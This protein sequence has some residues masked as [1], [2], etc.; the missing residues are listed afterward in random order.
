[1]K[2]DLTDLSDFN[3]IHSGEKCF[4]LGAGPSIKDLNLGAIGGHVVICVNSS[5]LLMDW[6]GGSPSRRYWISNDRQC[7]HWDYF[8]KQVVR[9]FS[10]KLI[11]TSWKKYNEKIS[12]FGFRYFEPRISEVYPFNGRDRG[13]CFGSSVPTAIDFAIMMGC[14]KVYLLGVDHKFVHGNSHFWQFWDRKKWPKRLD[15]A[16][17]YRPDQKHQQE[18]FLRNIDVFLA[19]NRYASDNGCVIKNCSSISTIDVFEKTSLL[20]ALRAKS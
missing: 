5:I 20:E 6:S 8:W 2:V 7:L 15:S 3:G 4:I 1:M 10:T 18:V 11:R 17:N 12:Q 13:L 16:S 9:S 19:L 14:S